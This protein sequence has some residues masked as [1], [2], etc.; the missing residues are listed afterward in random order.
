MS[1]GWVAGGYYDRKLNPN[2]TINFK[3]RPQCR[4]KGTWG[5]FAGFGSRIILDRGVC[6]S[7]QPPPSLDFLWRDW[8]L[9]P[10]THADPDL[11]LTESRP[12]RDNGR[13][14]QAVSSSTT[15]RGSPPVLPCLTAAI[16]VRSVSSFAIAAGTGTLP[17]CVH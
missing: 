8:P 13:V 7:Q 4:E 10:C 12:M 17:T 2:V 11:P 16:L 15:G 14:V 9:G 1:A 3:R 5:F 6:N